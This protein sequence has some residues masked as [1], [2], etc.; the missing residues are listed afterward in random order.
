MDELGSGPGVVT[1]RISPGKKNPGEFIGTWYT[2]G[3][4]DRIVFLPRGGN[5]MGFKDGDEVRLALEP[6]EHKRDGRGITMYRGTR[7]PIA[8][9][10]RLR[11]NEGVN[12][13]PE[14]ATTPWSEIV[15]DGTVTV[16]QTSSGP[17]VV[18]RL[19]TNYSGCVEIIELDV[20][21]RFQP[22]S[23]RVEV[24]DVR[25]YH[26]TTEEVIWQFCQVKRLDA[27]QLVVEVAGYYQ[28]EASFTN[29]VLNED[30]VVKGW[31]NG[32]KPGPKGRLLVTVTGVEVCL[33]VRP[34]RKDEPGDS[35]ERVMKIPFR[36]MTDD[37]TL[38]QVLMTWD[39]MPGWLQ[40]RV[41]RKCR[42]LSGQ[43]DEEPEETSEAVEPVPFQP[44]ADIGAARDKLV[45]AW[46]QG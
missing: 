36:V 37:F 21:W 40:A 13:L 46:H 16:S 14:M 42:E 43:P 28:S 41:A 31:F 27:D 4:G 10:K 44:V 45:S 30:G 8:P 22:V 33:G 35:T 18:K 11:V 26:W 32:Q 38:D 6:I 1:V 39:E 12:F 15:L 17:T 5:G 9:I 25:P 24:V 7:A 23:D 3:G 20:D 19:A 2:N 34:Y 29:R